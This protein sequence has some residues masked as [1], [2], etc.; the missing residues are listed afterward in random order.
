MWIMVGDTATGKGLKAAALEA[1][2]GTFVGTFDI[3][4][5]VH[6]PRNGADP[7]KQLSWL[8]LIADKRIALSSEA[9][10]N[11]VLCGALIKQV[12]SGGDSMVMRGNY[13]D[14][15]VHKNRSTFFM[16]CNDVPKI[17]PLD[18]A[19]LDRVG[20]FFEMQV[21]FLE[22]P[23]P[24]RPDFE[25][26]RDTTLK[27]KLMR[28]E[29]EA[30]FLSTLLDAYQEYRH[31]G[32]AIPASV[33]TAIREWVEDDNNFE[34]ILYDAFESKLDQSTPRKP[35]PGF[36]VPVDELYQTLVVNGVGAQRRKASMSKS[37]L[38]LSLER[39]GYPSLVKK[40]HGK[41]VRV[42]LGLARKEPPEPS[43]RGQLHDDDESYDGIYDFDTDSFKPGSDS[44]V[45]F[46][47]RIDREYDR[48][49]SGDAKA[50]V[51]K[52][53]ALARALCGDYES[54][55]MYIMAGGT[56]SGKGLKV[57]ALEA[58]C[59]TFVGTF[60]INN[61]VIRTPRDHADAAKLNW[62]KEIVDKRIALSSEARHDSILCHSLIKQ[63][64]SGGDTLL[65]RPNHKDDETVYKNRNTIFVMCNDVLRVE[66]LDDAVLD[67]QGGVFEMQVRFV[68]RP[69]PSMQEF[70]KLRDTTLKAKLMRPEYQA[71]FLSTLLDAY[72]EYR[73]AGH[74]IPAS[75]S[76][77]VKDWIVDDLV[78]Y[79]GLFFEAFESKLD[80]ATGTPL[81]G[82]SVP[83]HKL[84]QSLVV[85]G[86]GEGRR[87]VTMSKIK[88]SRY[89]QKLGYPSADRWEQGKMV[90]VRLGL[91]AKPVEPAS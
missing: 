50:E 23:N 6:N 18:N 69:N 24:F 52:R 51:M 14:E 64:V 3:N 90:R 71:A 21:C 89:M 48:C 76:T 26:P 20:G 54:R 7:A 29:Y 28:P 31:A 49:E 37:K 2:C 73:H 68:E 66:A 78:F 80:A 41:C 83:A 88:I 38:G 1:S 33:S 4:N 5:F 16:M 40:E 11:S 70:E 91:A 59:G 43:R 62:L 36:S 86:V 39:L 67:R 32:H 74:V 79:Q 12:M 84:Y 19:V 15:S 60:D 56:A 35:L 30:A 82:F 22:K 55:K 10:H 77:T 25:K 8:K 61:F 46:G 58:S 75:V 47:G 42:R 44:K 72:Q 13:Q 45:E 53:I 63:V 34:S 65:L 87:K 17:Q 27:R 81:P 57:A 85:D 9:R